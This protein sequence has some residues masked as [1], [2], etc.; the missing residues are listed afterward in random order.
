MRLKCLALLSVLGFAVACSGA[1]VP[2][3]ETPE[4]TAASTAGSP[5]AESPAATTE[6]TAQTTPRKDFPDLDYLGQ[7]PYGY[8]TANEHPQML[9]MI[10]CY[11]PCELYGHGGVVDC[12]RSQHAASCATCLEEGVLAGQLLEQAGGDVS[13]YAEVAAQVKARYRTAIV[14]SYVQRNQMPD[15]Q[16]AGGQAY[17]QA[18]SDCHQP[19]H[20]AMYTP[21][22]WPQPLAR[23]EAYARQ[24]GQEPDPQVWQRAVEY[25][26]ATSGRFPADAGAKYRQSLAEQ[27]EFLKAAEGES[28]Y[29]PSPQDEILSPEWFERMVRAYRLAQDIPA[30][31]L[32]AV[33]LDDPACDNL[34]DCLNSSAAIT[35]EAAVA[36]VERIAAERG[37]GD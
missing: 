11:C 8:R 32:A 34:L 19:P 4:P 18:C 2:S 3:R 13:R 12:Y 1:D 29:Y 35:S 23:M 28:A 15:L 33:Q 7:I 16:T 30:E 31:V 25:I 14:R 6:D 10:P 21:D 9:A 26:R 27:V 5:A 17:L 24:R 20:P 22:T 37:I 36:A